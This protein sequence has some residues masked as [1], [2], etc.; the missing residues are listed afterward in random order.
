MKIK[1]L[2]FNKKKMKY[3]FAGMLG[4]IKLDVNKKNQDMLL[5]LISEG[6]VLCG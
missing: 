1:G 3:L 2:I 5:E 6:D 4:E